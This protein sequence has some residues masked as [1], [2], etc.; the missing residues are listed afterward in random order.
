VRILV[1][2]SIV[3]LL[4]WQQ[5]PVQ[6]PFWHLPAGMGKVHAFWNSLFVLR[7][8]LITHH[9]FCLPFMEKISWSVQFEME[10]FLNPVQNSEKP[11]K[12][13]HSQSG[14]VGIKVKSTIV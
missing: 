12:K 11:S 3:A 1:I 13:E 2:G 8:V 6:N 5:K 10:T 14:K 9:Q 7:L 4:F